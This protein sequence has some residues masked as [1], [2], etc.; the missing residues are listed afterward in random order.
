MKKLL[1]TYHMFNAE[2]VAETCIVLPMAD[3]IADSI[4]MLGA[5]SIYLEP[6]LCGGGPCGSVRRA[7]EELSIMQDYYF[8]EFCTAEEVKKNGE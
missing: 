3:D 2:E 6:A 7:L 8:K 4:L 5:H 1:I